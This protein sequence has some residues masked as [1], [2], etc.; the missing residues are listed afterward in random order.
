[1]RLNFALV[2]LF[3]NK[4]ALRAMR[5]FRPFGQGRKSSFPEDYAAVSAIWSMSRPA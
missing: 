5:Q 2:P 4:T 1:M 3:V